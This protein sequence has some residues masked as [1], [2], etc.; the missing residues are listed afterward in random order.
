MQE[1]YWYYLLYLYTRS[2]PV[3]HSLYSI[4]LSQFSLIWVLWNK[5]STLRVTRDQTHPHQR[6]KHLTQLHTVVAR[7]QQKCGGE[8]ATCGAAVSTIQ[9]N[10]SQTLL[11][12]SWLR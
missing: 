3:Y 6:Q 5:C 10:K 7:P 2:K 1:K 12:S 8:I 11:S 4:Y 9:E